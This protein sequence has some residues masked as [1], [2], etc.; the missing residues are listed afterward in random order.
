METGIDSGDILAEKRFPIP[1][2]CFVSDLYELTV[3]KS[4]ELWKESAQGI[5][6]QSFKP[7]PQS[8]LAKT[9]GTAY[10]Y[11]HDIEK[12]KKID[13]SWEKEQIERHIRATL[14]PGFEGPYIEVV[15]K[16]IFF[17]SN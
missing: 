9:R 16:K 15:G 6:A 13:L 11:R 5:V 14:M 2:D 1:K 7:I 12:L 4:I 3:E 8:K 17:T 10:Y